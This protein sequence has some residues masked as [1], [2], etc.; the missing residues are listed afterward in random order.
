VR[1]RGEVIYRHSEEN[2]WYIAGKPPIAF[3][4]IREPQENRLIQVDSA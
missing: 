3:D 4:G 1:V 2:A